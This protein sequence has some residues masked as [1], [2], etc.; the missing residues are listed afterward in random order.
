MLDFLTV[1]GDTDYD[2]DGIW[3]SADDC[4][5]EYDRAM[6]AAIMVERCMLSKS[7]NGGSL[8]SVWTRPTSTFVGW[9]ALMRRT[10]SDDGS[11]FYPWACGDPLEY[12]GYDYATVQIQ[13]WFAE[14]LRA[15]N[16]TVMLFR[17]T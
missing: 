8:K 5:G 1:Y 17:Q 4:V 13:C 16:Y 9:G 3:D 2:Q 7:M 15:E 12:Q 14:N 11:C 10:T 6:E